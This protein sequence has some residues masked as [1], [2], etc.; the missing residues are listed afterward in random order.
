[1]NNII[2]NIVDSDTGSLSVCSALFVARKSYHAS[3]LAEF[4]RAKEANIRSAINKRIESFKVNKGHTIRSMLEH[5]FRKVVLDHLVVDDELILEP[6][7]VK[8]KVN[9]IME[10]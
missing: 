6:N 5:L 1:M 2:Q 7:L 8:S 3:K 10:D 9:V 4:L